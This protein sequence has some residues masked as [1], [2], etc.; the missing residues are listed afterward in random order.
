[1]DLEER[2]LGRDFDPATVPPEEQHMGMTRLARRVF[3]SFII[4]FAL[5]RS[6]GVLMMVGRMHDFYLRVGQTHVHHLNY[7]IFILSALGGYLIFIRPDARGVARAAALYGVGLALTFDEF[8]MWLHLDDVYW[9]RA[10]FDAMVLIA[11]ILG[12]LMAAPTIRR[13]RLKHWLWTAAVTAAVIYFTIL[14]MEPFQRVHRRIAPWFRNR[15]SASDSLLQP[16]AGPSQE[17]RK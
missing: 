14:L 17:I 7:G 9:Q 3:V 11:A 2:R 10:S 15:E 1:M 8:G 13:F 5:A 12:L 4:T 16:P 6:I